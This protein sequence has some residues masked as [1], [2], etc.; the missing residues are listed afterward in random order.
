MMKRF[1]SFILS[2]VMVVSMLPAQVLAEEFVEQPEPQETV[3]ATEPAATE[4]PTE[5]E[6]TSAPTE[7]EE[8][9]APAEPE[10]T[11]APTEAAPAEPEETTAPTEI[12][13]DLG[14]VTDEA[15]NAV[16]A[17]GSCGDNLTWTLEN[18][19]LTV[20]GTDRKSVV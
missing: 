5:P 20:S 14:T 3:A 16:T 12:V 6:A 13:E 7:P 15:A 9:E 8:T 2:V 4:A 11:A 19:V 18:S 10:A 17:S 1:L